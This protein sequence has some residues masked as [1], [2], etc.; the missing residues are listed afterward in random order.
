MQ[1]HDVME[2]LFEQLTVKQLLLS[3]MVCRAFLRHIDAN[4]TSYF[5][6]FLR[7]WCV[8]NASA[9][10][11]LPV[12]FNEARKKYEQTRVVLSGWQVPWLTHV[13]PVVGA[14]VHMR[15]NLRMLL[16]EVELAGKASDVRK[17]RQ[18][19]VAS[20]DT[21][22]WEITAVERTALESSVCRGFT[23]DVSMVLVTYVHNMRTVSLQMLQS[24]VL[25]FSNVPVLRRMLSYRELCVLKCVKC[26]MHC[27]QRRCRWKSLDV[28]RAEHRVLCTLCMNEFYIEESSISRKWKVKN[29][30]EESVGGV[31]RSVFVPCHNYTTFAIKKPRVCVLKAD[32]LQLLG[33]SH[34]TELLRRVGMK[35][36]D[37]NAFA[38]MDM[39]TRWF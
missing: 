28:Q 31:R 37:L 1:L 32:V 6:K 24:V 18:N 25:T 9:S 14:R 13:V 17:V 11:D 10:N 35:K 20:V 34:C 5:N 33:F 16:D 26:C 23:A 27:H 22:E 2:L 21:L 39:S 19:G 12:A 3:S 38:H 29:L 8:Y 4:K 7:W 15:M 36:K 30:P